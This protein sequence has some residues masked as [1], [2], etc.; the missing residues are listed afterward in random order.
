[1]GLPPAHAEPEIS[2]A[3]FKAL[4]NSIPNLAWMARPDG[5]VLWYNRRWYE[6]TGTTPEEMAGWGWQSVHHPD[7]LP[8]MLERWIYAI[9]RGES[10]EMTFP[11]RGKDGAYR[12]FLTRIQP[13]REN[14]SIVGWY[15]SNT[16]VTEQERDR[17]RLQL[18]V[19][20]LNHRVKNTLAT[21]HSIA[22]HSLREMKPDAAELFENRLLALAAVHDILT[23][24]SWTRAKIVELV[25]TAIAPAGAANFDVDGPEVDL[26]PSVAAALAMTLHELCT[27]AV[28]FGSLSGDGRVAISWR[29]DFCAIAPRLIFSWLETGGPAVAA[30][31][32]KGFG[33]RLIERTLAADAGGAVRLDYAPQGLR[34]D[35]HVP[36]CAEVLK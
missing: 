3:Q 14:G 7:V 18:L 23:S 35:I 22:A 6:Y 33:T 32:R 19:N 10:F 34:C 2:Y 16:D 8:K 28:K 5:W 24:E 9:E 11:L 31:S 36:L 1:M 27:N 20:E 13:L 26:S 25:R 15:G 30:P 17:E 29:V 21:I 4:A 12:P